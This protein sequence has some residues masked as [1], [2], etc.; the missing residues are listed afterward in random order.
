M[1]AQLVYVYIYIYIYSICT[2]T[3]MCAC[4]EVLLEFP[5]HSQEALVRVYLSKQ[6]GRIHRRQ[7]LH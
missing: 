3:L 7:P 1:N 2:R 6:L 4:A 5:G